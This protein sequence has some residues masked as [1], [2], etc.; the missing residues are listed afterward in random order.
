MIYVYYYHIKEN[1]N[2]NYL[3]LE[4]YLN[5]SDKIR[6]KKIINK[7]N[8]IQFLISRYLLSKLLDD[9]YNIAYKKLII[10]IDEYGKPHIA[11]STIHFNISHSANTIMVATSNNCLGIDIEQIKDIN[12]PKLYNIMLDKIINLRENKFIEKT[13]K[14]DFYQAWCIK[15][16][17][18]KYHGFGFA[19]NNPC[20]Y[21]IVAQKLVQNLWIKINNNKEE[22]LFGYTTQIQNNICAIVCNQESFI[23]FN[24]VKD[25][26]I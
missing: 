5:F 6:Y 17:F 1:H 12:N 14:K 20:D 25:I 21:D 16:A 19:K 15:E 2:D 8:K 11:N 24:E 23:N 26:T 4:K 13:D 22:A 3:L 7:Q 10:N 9:Y 18:C